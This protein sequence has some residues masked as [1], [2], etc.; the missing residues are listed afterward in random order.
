MKNLKFTPDQIP[1]IEI[2][3]IN[4]TIRLFD[5]KNLEVG[6]F[7]QF[8][9]SETGGNFGYGIIEQVT[10]KRLSS[11]ETIEKRFAKVCQNDRELLVTLHEFYGP[12]VTLDTVARVVRFAYLGKKP[13]SLVVEKAT[14]AEKIKLFTDGASRG[15]PG[16]SACGYVI[17]DM[18]DNIIKTGG[19]YL[20]EATNNK[21][22]Y[23]AVQM[24]LATAKDMCA[25]TVHV[26]MDS[27]LVV[28]QMNGVFKIKNPDLMQ[29]Y[30]V[31]KD[32]VAC[33][34]EVSFTHVPR[35]MN[36][37]AD[38]KVNEVLDTTENQSL[39]MI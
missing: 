28:N 20:G 39:K 7:I 9:N 21:A 11:L 1:E 4:T 38:A 27:L 14:S 30:K 31:T 16:P 23:Q 17:F 5:D 32:L 3:N 35:E 33:F 6:D 15:N 26:Y 22:E 2:G 10:Q 8:V 34:D 12:N 29:L 25:K 24:G 13:D 37:L 19:R 18:E 36:K